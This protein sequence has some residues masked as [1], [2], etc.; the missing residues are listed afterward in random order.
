MFHSNIIIS[1][2][3]LCERAFLQSYRYMIKQHPVRSIKVFILNLKN[4]ERDFYFFCFE[5]L[6]TS[7]SVCFRVQYEIPVSVI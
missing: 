6:I 5:K 3:S 7:F 2:F 4:D 1:F